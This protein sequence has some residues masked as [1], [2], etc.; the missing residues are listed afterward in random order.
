MNAH[1]VLE[2]VI[3]LIFTVL[4]S[5]LTLACYQHLVEH[6]GSNPGDGQDHKFYSTIEIAPRLQ[7]NVCL[8]GRKKHWM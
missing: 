8:P 1:Q 2:N 6:P 5:S 7:D 3:T 4:L